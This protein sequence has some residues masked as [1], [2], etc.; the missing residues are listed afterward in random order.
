MKKIMLPLMALICLAG[1][2]FMTSQT[3]NGFKKIGAKLYQTRG[4]P[5][6]N[7]TDETKFLE[8]LQR[9]YK[10][11]DLKQEITLS[12][13][14]VDGLENTFS[15]AE[16]KLSTA[17]FSQSLLENGSEYDQVKTNCDNAGNPCPTMPARKALQEIVA[18]Y[19]H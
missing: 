18:K 4:V 9:E 17:I 15:M 8:V 1:M 19:T 3:E 6:L 10:I 14:K 7:K 5:K 11:K 16:K 2:S 12:Y 13:R